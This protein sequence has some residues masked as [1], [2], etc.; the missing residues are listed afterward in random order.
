M[1]F[2]IYC[3]IHLIHLKSVLCDPYLRI[4]VFQ[5]KRF[6]GFFVLQLRFRPIY[7]LE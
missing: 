1:A 3:V 7:M 5:L 4:T 2:V 6:T